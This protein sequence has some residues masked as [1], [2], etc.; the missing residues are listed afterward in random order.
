GE[1]PE[2]V[3][4]RLSE[5]LSHKLYGISSDSHDQRC[6]GR[7]WVVIEAIRRLFFHPLSHVPGPRLAALTWWY[8]FYYDV[9]LPGK[10]IFKIQ[11]LH[12]EYGTL[13]WV[14]EYEAKDHVGPILRITPDEIHINDVGFLDTVYSGLRDKYE[15]PLR[16]LRVPGE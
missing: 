2:L 3:L 11:E 14:L 8:E 12:S 13:S 1:L 10:Y 9:V 15:Y 6:R 16:A 5:S 7:S 4:D